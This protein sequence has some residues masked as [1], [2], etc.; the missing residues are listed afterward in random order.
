M[1]Q[2]II[3]SNTYELDWSSISAVDL[4]VSEEPAGGDDSPALL[5]PGSMIDLFDSELMSFSTFSSSRDNRSSID[6]GVVTNGDF[7]GT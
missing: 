4:D 5:T 6:G 3:A 7:E 1:S 2:R